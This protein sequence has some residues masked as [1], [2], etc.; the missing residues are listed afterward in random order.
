MWK[1]LYLAK[2][3]GRNVIA[4]G[5]VSVMDDLLRLSRH[6][7]DG[8]GGAIVGKALYT[9]SIDLSEAVRAVSKGTG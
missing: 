3:S 6:A 2:A 9:G 1:P 4:S 7:D 8:I 5:G